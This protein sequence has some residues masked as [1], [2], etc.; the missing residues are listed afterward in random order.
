MCAMNT[1]YL[2]LN[3][4]AQSCIN[5]PV[6]LGGIAGFSSD[7]SSNGTIY[8]NT[9][10]IRG[11]ET[12]TGNEFVAGNFGVTGTSLLTGVVTLGAAILSASS[13][14][15]GAITATTFTGT[16]GTF[17]STLTVGG[18]ATLTSGIL[19]GG[20]VA[21]PVSIVA[22][23]ARFFSR[24]TTASGTSLV[25]QDGEISVTNLSVTSCTL[26]YRSGATTYTFRADAAS[27]L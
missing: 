4:S 22:T 17:T 10:V 2:S 19:V 9:L 15:V 12:L 7:I 11:S 26:Q 25:N 21:S 1:P 14:S 5:T 13:A 27:V 23:G 8:G 24:I 20:T 16:T 3:T 6:L 18:I